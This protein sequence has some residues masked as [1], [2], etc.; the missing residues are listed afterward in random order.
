MWRPEVKISVSSSTVLKVPNPEL[1][2]PGW[3]SNFYRSF[4]FSASQVRNLILLSHGL[5]LNLELTD[6]ARLA[7]NELQG[8]LSRLSISCTGI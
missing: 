4:Y 7:D 6:S 2:E 1:C 8:Y 3:V 5:S